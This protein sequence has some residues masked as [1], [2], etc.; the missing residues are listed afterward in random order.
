MFGVVPFFNVHQ[1]SM[2]VLFLN[3]DFVFL[4]QN[5]EGHFHHVFPTFVSVEETPKVLD[6][7][8]FLLQLLRMRANSVAYAGVACSS[9]LW[10]LFIV[11]EMKEIVV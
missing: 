1:L 6:Q 9:G 10:V 8:N 5:L 11:A 3:A 2:L 7:S 4:F